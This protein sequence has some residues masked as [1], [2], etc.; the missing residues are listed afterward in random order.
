[1]NKQFLCGNQ[2]DVRYSRGQPSRIILVKN[3]QNQVSEEQIRHTFSETG[4]RHFL[5]Y[6]DRKN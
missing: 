1:M 5:C 3:V 6:N 4:N 2:I